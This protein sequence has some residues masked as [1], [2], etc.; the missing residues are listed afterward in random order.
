[1]RQYGCNDTGAALVTKHGPWKMHASLM[2]RDG[3]YAT[4]PLNLRVHLDESQP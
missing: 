3:A 2:I 1:M 4:V